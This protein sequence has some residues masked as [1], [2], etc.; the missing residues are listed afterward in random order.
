MEK[1]V[2]IRLIKYVIMPVGTYYFVDRFCP[3][4]KQ[5]LDKNTVVRSNFFAYIWYYG[6]VFI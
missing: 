2:Y 1:I 3:K 6:S 4:K 5:N